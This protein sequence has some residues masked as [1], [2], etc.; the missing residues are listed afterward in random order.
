MTK[1]I[2]KNKVLDNIENLEK[3]YG[4]D[5]SHW[6]EPFW[7]PKIA[8]PDRSTTFLT[9]P[10]IDPQPYFD[11][12]IVML[13]YLYNKVHWIY[14][15]VEKTCLYHYPWFYRLFPRFIYKKENGAVWD[16]SGWIQQSGIIVP[17]SSVHI[18]SGIIL[19]RQTSRHGK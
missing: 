9:H 1:D 10:S 18:Y 19:P 8:M 7:N 12:N 5:T 11:P 2:T 16:I 13:T 17:I 14:V 3:S 6:C 4:L 15:I